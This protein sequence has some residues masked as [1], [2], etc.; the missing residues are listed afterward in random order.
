[1][2]VNITEFQNVTQTVTLGDGNKIQN[3]VA[4]DLY[5]NGQPIVDASLPTGNTKDM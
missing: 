5:N 1:M 4:F 3:N 2:K